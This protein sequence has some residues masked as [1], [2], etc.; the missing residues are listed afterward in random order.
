[1]DAN[2]KETKQKPH[3]VDKFLKKIGVFKNTAV[4]SLERTKR[5]RL[6]SETAYWLW[7]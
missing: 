6:L 1:M 7:D 3:G 2:H 4:F 5:E